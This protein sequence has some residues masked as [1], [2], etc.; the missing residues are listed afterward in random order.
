MTILHVSW[1]GEAEEG[2]GGLCT[3]Q[4][5]FPAGLS[6]PVDIGPPL[7]CTIQ[8]VVVWLTSQGWRPG[9]QLKM[10]SGAWDSPTPTIQE[11]SVPS[12][13][14]ACRLRPTLSHWSLPGLCGPCSRPYWSRR[15]RAQPSMRPPHRARSPA[16]KSSRIMSTI[17]KLALKS[18][19]NL[20][21]STDLS[22]CNF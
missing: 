7:I 20:T 3:R 21:R 5:T 16:A 12:P 11:P 18:H 9:V 19:S 4:H 14:G 22:K 8:G 13:R 1:G 17:W 15:P 10:P 2:A 6:G